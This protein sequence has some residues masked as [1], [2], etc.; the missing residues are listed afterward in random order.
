[1]LIIFSF[2]HALFTPMHQFYMADDYITCTGNPGMG[3][4]SVPVN[5]DPKAARLPVTA[6]PHLQSS[7][8]ALCLTL[9]VV[10]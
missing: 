1:M 10:L 5:I 2:Q 6:F 4:L 9:T 3:F 7:L 8:S